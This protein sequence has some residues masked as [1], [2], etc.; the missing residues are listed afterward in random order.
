MFV[1]LGVRTLRFRGV[2]SSGFRHRVAGMLNRAPATPSTLPKP[3]FAALC[4]WI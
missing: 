3:C 4:D 2:S 1:A